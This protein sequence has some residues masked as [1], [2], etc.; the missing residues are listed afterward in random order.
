MRSWKEYH[1]L[2]TAAEATETWTSPVALQRCATGGVGV[3]L[4][5]GG[6]DLPKDEAPHPAEKGIGA[7]V[8]DVTGAGPVIDDTDLAPSLQVITEV[9]DIG[10]IQNLLKGLRKATRRAGEGMNSELSF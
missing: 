3:G 7:R 10:A 5:E 2:T 4:P 9:T 6:V 1:H 8:Q